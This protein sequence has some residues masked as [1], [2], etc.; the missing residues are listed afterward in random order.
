VTRRYG[1]TTLRATW[2]ANVL[3]RAALPVPS[4]LSDLPVAVLLAAL[5]STRPLPV[6]LEQ[7]LRKREQGAARDDILPLDPLR[8]FDES[9]LLLERVRHA[10]LALWQLGE[11]L[12]RP[13]NSLDAVRW[14]LHGVVG[15]VAIADGLVRAARSEETLPGEVH[16][17]LAELALTLAAVEW[18]LAESVDRRQAGALVRDVLVGISERL[19]SLPAPAHHALD[20]YVSDAVREAL[21]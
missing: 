17:L 21:R 7:A 12:A 18:N 9:G 13:C 11:R 8:R 14:R 19:E 16:F 1:G 3:D 2:T 4:D 20:D 10:S 6:A 15:P 5:A